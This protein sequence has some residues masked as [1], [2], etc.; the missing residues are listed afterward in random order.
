MK[1]I[2]AAFAVAI[3]TLATASAVAGPSNIKVE[4]VWARATPKG[5]V[6][7]AAY[8]TLVDGGTSDDRLL[9]A[10]SPLAEKIRFHSMTDDKGIMKMDELPAIDLHP[11]VPVVLKPGGIHMMIVGLRQQLKEGQSLPLTL[12][13]EK[14]GSVATTALVGKV[15]AMVEPGNHASSGD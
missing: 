5:A 6:T 2:I 12:T 13:F 15:G 7:A 11:G 10:S 14:A 9:G 3:G 1:R 4:H 8:A